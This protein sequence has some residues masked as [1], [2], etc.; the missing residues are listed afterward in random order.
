M[1]RLL[2]GTLTYQSTTG[3]ITGMTIPAKSLVL[4]VFA[5]P[6]VAFNGTTFLISL[7]DSGAAAGFLPNM[8]IANS[9]L[10][11]LNVAVGAECAKRGPLLWSTG[12]ASPIRAYYD[13][14]NHVHATISSTGIP[15]T[16]AM[17][18]YCVYM[19]LA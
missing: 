19:Q 7:E 17:T 6:T 13:T 2:T 3:N 11:T 9:Q 12:D 10:T 4:D 1:V 15:S 14:T 16:G 8:T 5:I 18:V